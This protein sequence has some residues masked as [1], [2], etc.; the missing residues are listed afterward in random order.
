MSDV[1]CQESYH[2]MNR[3]RCKKIEDCYYYEWCV[4]HKWLRTDIEL[5][6]YY[7][8]QRPRNEIHKLDEE[9]KE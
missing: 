3:C 7:H 2:G 9:E 5:D 8:C 6:G 1:D 4:Q